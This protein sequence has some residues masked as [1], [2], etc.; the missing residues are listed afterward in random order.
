M[1]YCERGL[2]VIP[3]LSWHEAK[4]GY[5]EVR[6]VCGDWALS[7][8]CLPTLPLLTASHILVFVAP[9]AVTWTSAGSLQ[10]GHHHLHNNIRA[11]ENSVGN[12]RKLYT[13]IILQSILRCWTEINLVFLIQK[14]TSHFNTF[15]PAAIII[16]FKECFSLSPA[17]LKIANISNG[18]LCHQYG[19][20]V[21]RFLQ[22]ENKYIALVCSGDCYTVMLWDCEIVIGL[23]DR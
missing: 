7:R 2:N 13:V 15:R 23:I 6:H 20:V 14:I 16:Q 22:S 9:T 11:K 4:A 5:R 21:L 1:S 10:S 19:I 12:L 18:F 8:Y 17:R 3:G